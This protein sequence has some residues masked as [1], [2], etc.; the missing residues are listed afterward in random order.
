MI[1]ESLYEKFK[2]QVFRQEVDGTYKQNKIESAA[3]W[4]VLFG[5]LNIGLGMLSYA[6]YF[7]MGASTLKYSQDAMRDVYFGKG[8]HYMYIELSKFHQ[9]HLKYTK[10]LSYEQLSG[11]TQNLNLT[12]CRP[13]AYRDGRPYYPAGLIANTFFQDRIRIKGLPIRSTGIS[14][15]SEKKVVG[16]SGYRPSS[17]E[18]PETWTPSTNKGQT[19][20]NSAG[21]SGLPI[22]DE[23]FV[24][25]IYLST[26]S[27]VRKLWGIID[28]K[29]AGNYT[30]EIESIFD[31]SPKAL[32]FTRMSWMGLKNYFLC[33]SLVVLG[34]VSVLSGV[35][36]RKCF[37]NHS[38]IH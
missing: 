10:S 1:G 12:H 4:M 18:I 14:W 22:L 38:P 7:H 25:W 35:C 28:V 17:I 9:N 24:N 36:I 31:F 33:A 20:L 15:G 27:R 16:I 30:V 23:R 2:D 6:T 21:R 29:E 34:V 26:F 13:Y 3:K 11:K 5:F 37:P 19:P 8:T 32:Y